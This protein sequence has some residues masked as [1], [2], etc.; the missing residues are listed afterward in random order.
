MFATSR[1]SAVILVSRVNSANPD[2]SRNFC[3]A[4]WIFSDLRLW[5]YCVACRSDRREP[6]DGSTERPQRPRTRTLCSGRTSHKA[7][8]SRADSTEL[9]I[10]VSAPH[11]LLLAP[12]ST[13]DYSFLITIVIYSQSIN[14][15]NGIA[16]DMLD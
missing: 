10:H 4:I 15:F 13:A 5:V 8:D 11:S 3:L 1:I 9:W 16:A 14:D 12:F 6:Q 2:I 7:E